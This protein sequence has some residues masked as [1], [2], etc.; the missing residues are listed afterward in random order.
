[1][2]IEGKKSN[3]LGGLILLFLLYVV[4]GGL[5][6][7]L[8]IFLV[9]VMP[10][11]YLCGFAAVAYGAI[12]A[13]IVAMCKKGFHISSSLGAML[14]VLAAIAI[15]SYFKWNLFFALHDC[16]GQFWDANLEFDLFTDFEYFMDQLVFCINSPG[17]FI[18]GLQWYNMAGTWSYG[19]NARS[20]V[21]GVVLGCI[22]IGE[23]LILAVPSLASCFTKA[24]PKAAPLPDNIW[25]A[26]AS[27]ETLPVIDATA[28]ANPAFDA[29]AV[30]GQA[31]APQTI[32][33]DGQ[34]API[35]NAVPSEQPEEDAYKSIA[36][37][38]KDIYN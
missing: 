19:E 35:V 18:G 23:F 27:G 31:D 12:M 6:S 29:S 4:I 22:W 14:V 34:A 1:M 21:T 17:D 16:R 13:R 8:Y 33:L 10:S 26:P 2:N 9:D 20:N 5:I 38:E 11:I 37:E 3:N 25:Q 30:I 28:Q 36:D 7:I 24:A 32:S 15:V